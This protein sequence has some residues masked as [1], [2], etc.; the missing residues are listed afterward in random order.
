M[1]F[2]DLVQSWLKYYEKCVKPSTVRVR[3]HESGHLINYFETIKAKNI[4]KKMYQDALISLKDRLSDNTIEG[5]HT[6]GRMIFGYALEFDILKTNPTQYATVSRTQKTVE[7]IEN[8]KE[9]PKYL[10][11]EQLSLFLGAAK[12][13][14][15]SGDYAMFLTL[16]YSGMRA[17]ELCALK[18]NDIDFNEQNL[19]ITK[20]YYN[21][22]N[23]NLKYEL[24]TPK[25]NTSI[26]K[27]ELASIMLDELKKAQSSQNE[28]MVLYR[29]TYHDKGFVFVNNENY[30]VYPMYIK[31]IENS[32]ETYIKAGQSCY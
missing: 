1:L 2:K 13:K 4:T 21:P 5:V 9:I 25:T 32:N 24:L 29:K 8:T 6:S 19:S 26:R 3:K 17:G 11:K 28:I 31:M 23:N 7:D 20:T 15:L 18:W 27:I 16:A 30:P 14:G 12:E 22:T 10:E